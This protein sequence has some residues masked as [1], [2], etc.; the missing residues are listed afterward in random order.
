MW[1][2]EGLSS[3]FFFYVNG[4]IY[5]IKVVWDYRVIRDASRF[6]GGPRATG[7]RGSSMGNEKDLFDDNQRDLEKAVED[8]SEL[9]DSPIETENIPLLRQKV[10]DKTVRF[11]SSCSRSFAVT[12]SS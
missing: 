2:V 1:A 7:M 10:T 12:I 9:L 5:T 3:G 4:Y 11:F 6:E 8:L